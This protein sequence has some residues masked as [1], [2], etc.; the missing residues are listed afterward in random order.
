MR[1]ST[2]AGVLAL[3]LSLAPAACAGNHGAQNAPRV[4]RTVLHVV[5]RQ[6]R[7]YTLYVNSGLQQQRLGTVQPVSSADLVIPSAFVQTPTSLRFIADPIGSDAV[8]STFNT[9]VSPGETV[10]I[11]IVF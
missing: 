8:A 5:N 11:S 9:N 10:S 6:F 4:P 2:L 3:A 1:R 7:A